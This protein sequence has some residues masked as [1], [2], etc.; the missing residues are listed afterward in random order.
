[1]TNQVVGDRSV[2]RDA[3]DGARP[4]EV[5]SNGVPIPFDDQHFA[6]MR[7]S[8]DL[9]GDPEALRRQ[10]RQDGYL[11]LRRVLDPAVA[12]E[13]RG[14]YFSRFDAA[15]FAAGTAPQDGIFSGTLPRLPAYGTSGHPAYDFVRSPEFTQFTT[16]SKLRGLAEV[17][18]D[19]EVELVPRRIVRH[20]HRLS[21]QASR[22]HVDYDYMDRG[23]D[24][25]VTQW[26]PLGDCP[27][28]CGGLIYLEGSHRVPRAALDA[29][30]QHT[31]RPGDRRPVS[32]DLALTARTLGGR[33][34]W[35]D[36][37]AGDV[38]VH[39]PHTVHAS[40]DNRSDFMRLSADIRF[41]RTD[42]AP[43]E[44][45]NAAWSADDGF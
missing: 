7:D 23:G 29:L 43:D 17:L 2:R 22:A 4:A 33:W 19:G 5:S 18:L 30:R 41:R 42:N 28:Q 6:P 25:L 38:V 9:L 27:I 12:R 13:L 3:R 8:T 32:N 15:F 20:F 14:R 40:L 34:L 11:L 10:F 1:V 44:R 24:R 37:A 36:F 31:D 26:I 39:S 16:T 21:G 45:W 35:A